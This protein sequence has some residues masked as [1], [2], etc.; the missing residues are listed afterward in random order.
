MFIEGRGMTHVMTMA[1]DL[2]TNLQC[3]RV[4]LPGS[5]ES[6]SYTGGTPTVIEVGWDRW[7]A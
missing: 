3:H 4:P 7:V 1:S 2:V 5:A 6:L